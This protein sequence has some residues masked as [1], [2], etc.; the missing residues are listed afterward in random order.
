LALQIAITF[1]A[2]YTDAANLL[3]LPEIG[4]IRTAGVAIFAISISLMIFSAIK[5]G[6]LFSKSINVQREHRLI[7]DG[8]FRFLR[9]PWDVGVI[10]FGFGISLCFLSIIA[11]ILSIGLAITY[12]WRIRE[13]EAFM[14]A[15]FGDDWRE[16]KGRTKKM[17]PFL[18]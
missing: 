3:K 13:E 5:L 10:L 18:Y 14:E 6:N 4:A 11:F 9:H 7:T 15:E 8:I 1:I 17:V 12:L 2:P 16:Y